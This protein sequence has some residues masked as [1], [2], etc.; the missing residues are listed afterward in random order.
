MDVQKKMP[1]TIF[2]CVRTMSHLL[3]FKVHHLPF[4]DGW[5][6]SFIHQYLINK[7]VRMFCLPILLK[8]WQ[9]IEI[10]SSGFE[11]MKGGLV[12]S[13]LFPKP[14]GFKFYRDSM[15]FIGMLGVLGKCILPSILKISPDIVSLKAADIFWFIFYS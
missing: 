8:D 15:K 9:C 1:H 2:K 5:K 10:L 11:T 12:R 4:I 3:Y 14:V 6:V 13:I 7:R